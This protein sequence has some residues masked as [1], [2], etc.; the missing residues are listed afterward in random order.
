MVK[1]TDVTKMGA[2]AMVKGA[3]AAIIRAL[4]AVIDTGA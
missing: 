4:C 3:D 1:G 2:H